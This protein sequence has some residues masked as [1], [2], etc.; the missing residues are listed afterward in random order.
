VYEINQQ[1]ESRGRK[2]CVVQEF[3][4]IDLANPTEELVIAEA[5]AEDGGALIMK[6]KKLIWSNWSASLLASQ[7]AITRRPLWTHLCFTAVPDLRRST[8]AS[9]LPLLLRVCL[10][11]LRASHRVKPRIRARSQ[12]WCMTPYMR[13]TQ[14]L[15]PSSS[16]SLFGKR[17]SDGQWFLQDAA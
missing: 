15:G 2:T 14:F 6:M 12:W 8:R 5:A 16:T 10:V 13:V 1:V 4:T 9:T 17:S 11:L 3:Q 7:G